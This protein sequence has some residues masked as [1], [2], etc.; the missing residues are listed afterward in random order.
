[1]IKIN[2]IVK[3]SIAEELD[4]QE[5]DLLVSING[6][7]VSDELDYRFHS[8]GEELEVQIRQGDEEVIFEIEKDY[9]EDLGLVLEDMTMRKCGNR[10]IFCFV[11]QNPKGLRRSLYF[12]DEDYRF[13]FLYGHYVTLSN[14]TRADLERIVEQRLTPLYVSVHVTDPEKRKFMLGIKYDDH[15]L[16]KIRY[17]TANGIELNC[18]IVLCP[19]INDGEFL[20][21]TIADLKSFYPLVKSVAIVPVGLTGHRRNLP[22]IRPV[23]VDYSLQMIEEVDKKR[24]RLR[25]ELGSSFIYLS[26]EFF[27]RT[28]LPIPAE[29]YYEDF[30]QLENGVGLTRD[31]M[32]RLAEEKAALQRMNTDRR[33]TLVSGILGSA[34]LK[35]YI[36]PE[37][38]KL[39]GLQAKL[40]PVQNRFFGESIVVAGLLVGQDIYHELK[41]K[42][43]GDYVVLPPRVLNHD[44]IFLDDWTTDELEERLGR[45][46]FIFPDSFVH[47]FENITL[48]EQAA[49]PDEA[50]RIRH[51]GPSL[52][53]AEPLK[54]GGSIN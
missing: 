5:G 22:E 37:L 20:D 46:V 7:E 12:K 41:D 18:Q 6:R 38:Q 9:Q 31:L 21:R 14:T 25:R 28:G 30:Y 10:C 51:S 44:G 35:Q 50:K 36:L 19:D 33:L 8:A 53:I 47:L 24:N 32:N 13:S 54:G 40:Y 2:E 23:T 27:I 39:S 29:A 45:P 34:A 48:H 4:L 42:P 49:S 11:H 3:G 16:D 1:M 43:L 17:L 26:D 15:L 52:Y